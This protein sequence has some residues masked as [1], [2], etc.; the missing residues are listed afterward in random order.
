MF[1][2]QSLGSEVAKEA[3]RLNTGSTRLTQRIL[4]QFVSATRE[5]P[6]AGDV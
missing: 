4:P 2:G 5:S 6:R 3:L 1:E